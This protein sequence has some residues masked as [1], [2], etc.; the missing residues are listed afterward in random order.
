[1][2]AVSVATGTPLAS[3]DAAVD[4]QQLEVFARLASAA[5]DVSMSAG[6]WT[7][8]SILASGA[9]DSEPVAAAMHHR[10]L[11]LLCCMQGRPGSAEVY[12]PGSDAL[13]P[14]VPAPAVSAPQRQ[15]QS[16]VQLL[17]WNGRAFEIPAEL[18]LPVSAPDAVTSDLP[19]AP[20]AVAEAFSANSPLQ[21]PKGAHSAPPP[22]DFFDM[23]LQGLIVNPLDM[24][25][26]QGRHEASSAPFV[27]TQGGVPV[28]AGRA[29]LDGAIL[30]VIRDCIVLSKVALPRQQAG[31]STP[32]VR[33]EEGDLPAPPQLVKSTS[34]SS[35]GRLPPV[36]ASRESSFPRGDI[37]Y[38]VLA[39]KLDFVHL[40][41]LKRALELLFARRLGCASEGRGHSPSGEACAPHGITSAGQSSK[42]DAVALV[43]LI[44]S[45]PFLQLTLDDA[46]TT[47][48]NIVEEARRLTRASV[49][50]S[51][52]RS[53]AASS[54]RERRRARKRL[55]L[56]PALQRRI[57]VRFAGW[58]RNAHKYKSKMSRLSRVGD[59]P[60]TDVRAPADEASLAGKG[61]RHPFAL[62]MTDLLLPA[63]LSQPLVTAALRATAGS[64][65]HTEPITSITDAVEAS[66]AGVVLPSDPPKHVV[67][68]PEQGSWRWQLLRE[69]LAALLKS[70]PMG[71]LSGC[72]LLS[73]YTTVWGQSVSPASFGFHS[74]RQLLQAAD[75]TFVLETWLQAATSDPD[76]CSELMQGAFGEA[77]TPTLQDDFSVAVIT[78]TRA[79]EE[80]YTAALHHATCSCAAQFAPWLLPVAQSPGS[81][82]E[83]PRTSALLDGPFPSGTA[84]AGADTA[85]LYAS[86]SSAP[87]VYP[88]SVPSGADESADAVSPKSPSPS[89]QRQRSVSGQQ[90]AEGLLEAGQLQEI[91]HEVVHSWQV[92]L[93]GMYVCI[94]RLSTAQ[95][96]AP[97]ESAE[98]GAAA[99]PAVAAQLRFKKVRQAL[100]DAGLGPPALAPV[101]YP[102]NPEACVPYSKLQLPFVSIMES[103]PWAQVGSDP[104]TKGKVI[105]VPYMPIA[106][107]PPSAD[108][109]LAQLPSEDVAIVTSWVAA[110]AST[111]AAA[112]SSQQLRTEAAFESSQK[113]SNYAMFAMGAA[114]GA[115]KLPAGVTMAH[116]DRAMQVVAAKLQKFT[117]EQTQAYA[118][119]N[120][121]PGTTPPV[122]SAGGTALSRAQHA[123]ELGLQP[124]DVPMHALGLELKG[125]RALKATKLRLKTFLASH[126]AQFATLHLPAGAK[127]TLYARLVGRPAP[128]VLSSQQSGLHRAQ[129]IPG[130]QRSR[131]AVDGQEI[132]SSP[133]TFLLGL[134][135]VGGAL[136]GMPSQL[137]GASSIL[138]QA[139]APQK[140][141]AA[142]PATSPVVDANKASADA[143]AALQSM[144]AVLRRQ[145]S[146]AWGQRLPLL[147]AGGVLGSSTANRHGP[148]TRTLDQPASVTG[149]VDSDGIPMSGFVPLT[150]LGL[151]LLSQGIV[152]PAGT[153]LGTWLVQQSMPLEVATAL[154][155]S[156]WVRLFETSN[157]ALPT[158]FQG[159][160]LSAPAA[161]ACGVPPPRPDFT[162]SMVNA[163]HS[164]RSNVSPLGQ[165]GGH[166]SGGSGRADAAISLPLADAWSRLL[167]EEQL[168]SRH[169]VH[170]SNI[171]F[172]EDAQHEFKEGLLGGAEKAIP[173]IAPKYIVSFLNGAGGTLYFG[174]TDDGVVQGVYVNREQ[175]DRIN[176]ARDTMMQNRIGPPG[177]WTQVAHPVFVPVFQAMPSTSAEARHFRAIPDTFVIQFLVQRSPNPAILHYEVKGA[178]TVAGAAPRKGKHSAQGAAVKYMYW[179]RH[180]ASTRRMEAAAEIAAW[181]FARGQQHPA[182]AASPQGALLAQPSKS[183]AP[184]GMHV[185]PYPAPDRSPPLVGHRAGAQAGG[186][187]V[188]APRGADAARRAGTSQA[189]SSSPIVVD[190]DPHYPQ[191]QEVSIQLQTQE[192]VQFTDGRGDKGG[193]GAM[194]ASCVLTLRLGQTPIKPNGIAVVVAAV[195]GSSPISAIVKPGALLLKVNGSS[196]DGVSL[197]QLKRRLAGGQVRRLLLFAPL[198]AQPQGSSV[199]AASVA[200]RGGSGHPSYAA[201]ASAGGG[202]VELKQDA[203]AAEAAA[204]AGLQDVDVGQQGVQPPP[205]WKSRIMGG[206]V[207]GVR[208]TAAESDEPTRLAQPMQRLAEAT[209]HGNRAAWGA[210][211]VRRALARAV[212]RKPASDDAQDDTSSG[213]PRRFAGMGY[214]KRP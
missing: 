64:K 155:G 1:M 93:W 125:N 195:H 95:P 87:N 76:L 203:G 148:A 14:S 81:A 88:L 28:W 20:C 48:S 198:P 12:L 127:S 118:A 69:R 38:P 154:D 47:V 9:Q 141:E 36:H 143:I 189:Q 49:G 109:T 173:G 124:A 171:G 150:E 85:D 98:G 110:V 181:A 74:L 19:A 32:P 153:T 10:W 213:T 7:E 72:M 96:E 57:A 180:A 108:A 52:Q 193:Y 50:A 84:D 157:G 54:A 209:N 145:L 97:P 77:G 91:P 117:G 53:D 26:H 165:E 37:M 163:A 86:L 174:V 66:A 161:L 82:A 39:R 210:S 11:T 116:I 100:N 211:G 6:R 123:V 5:G 35:A 122:G 94:S 132:P 207:G 15:Q 162:G 208:H 42:L 160:V 167:T 24:A 23:Q 140:Q 136:G 55:G 119:Y 170:G 60:A 46:A 156:M 13:P 8:S 187:A 206:G 134:G 115:P 29:T 179:V 90:Q 67:P 186:V 183:Q 89:A 61:W 30:S 75:D 102:E 106:V 21:P 137:R 204:K 138:L 214:Q 114:G 56:P 103:I 177:T 112:A 147:Q 130:L 164:R 113:C 18:P 158:R 2:S 169:Y 142:A 44:G 172:D 175:R 185:T 45:Y 41:V 34:A 191:F 59:L 184:S 70:A 105:T 83:Q 43:T 101:P 146:A 111:C 151:R 40:P 202:S 149:P 144:H 192:S 205:A 68:A 212:G 176:L 188:S 182:A 17:T 121:T 58:L 196:V 131:S 197:V 107:P 128:L 120:S 25:A 78:P 126:C 73:C 27:R 80:A 129:S 166:A 62:S 199:K 71:V 63:E 31:S 178:G 51:S 33:H 3:D 133:S 135:S 190:F 92:Y 99:Q 65:V 16:A 194:G 200:A 159:S 152:L 168:P 4:I 79:K 104:E 139:P 201:A 22:A